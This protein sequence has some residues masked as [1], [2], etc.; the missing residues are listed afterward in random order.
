[1]FGL[2]FFGMFNIPYSTRFRFVNIN[3]FS[4]FFTP[5]LANIPISNNIKLVFKLILLTAY[6]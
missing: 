4:F 5:I 2:S 3:L 1:M 6:K